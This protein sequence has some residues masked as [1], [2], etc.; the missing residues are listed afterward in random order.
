MFIFKQNENV[1]RK[2]AFGVR[3]DAGNV[4]RKAKILRDEK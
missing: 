4:P 3:P 2:V 1:K